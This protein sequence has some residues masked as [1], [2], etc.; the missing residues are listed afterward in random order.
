MF[1]QVVLTQRRG[2]CSADIIINQ[3]ISQNPLIIDLQ[4]DYDIESGEMS[5]LELCWPDLMFSND[6]L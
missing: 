6:K 2:F 5:L 1:D 4:C 3:F